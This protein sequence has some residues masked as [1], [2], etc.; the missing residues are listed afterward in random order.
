MSFHEK[1][2]FAML[3]TLLIIYGGYFRT[4]FAMYET[5]VVTMA[6]AG[7]MMIGAVIGII[8]L[9][10]VFHTTIAI[11]SARNSEDNLDQQDERDRLIRLRGDAR[12]SYVLGAGIIAAI[13]MTFLEHDSFVVGNVLLASLV[14]A[15][16]AKTL[17]VILDYR[18][19]L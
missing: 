13:A 4:A 5:G 2:A 18:R 3:A 16:I 8:V 12:S 6:A 10:I 9:S 15:E 17:L 1:S 14:L 19:G 7:P 11:F